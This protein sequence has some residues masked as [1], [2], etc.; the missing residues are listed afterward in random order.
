VEAKGQ[1]YSL[2]Q[3]EAVMHNMVAVDTLRELAARE[4]RQQV[5]VVTAMTAMM[6]QSVILTAALLAKA[7]QGPVVRVDRRR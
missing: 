1:G 2:P 4:E 7:D 5:A 3:L 6:Q